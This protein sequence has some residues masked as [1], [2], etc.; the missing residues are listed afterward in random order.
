MLRFA[1][2][3]LV[4]C[5]VPLNAQ[6]ERKHPDERNLTDAPGTIRL[7]RTD[8]VA[9]DPQLRAA[10]QRL[11]GLTHSAVEGPEYARIADVAEGDGRAAVLDQGAFELVLL[12][13]TLNEIGRVGQQGSGPLD[14]RTPVGV[15]VEGSSVVRVYDAVLGFKRVATDT[16]G[17]SRL[18]SVVQPK[19]LAMS[20]CVA[21][22]EIVA[23]AP[24]SLA[25]PSAAV[26]ESEAL[27]AVF[28]ATD[29]TIIRNFGESYRASNALTRRIMSE[30]TVGCTASGFT[31][32]GYISLP[33]LRVYSPNGE[34]RW[35]Y[36]LA[37]Y[38]QAFQ[39]ER[40]NERGQLSIG[41]D[42]ST[43]RFSQTRRVVALGSDLLVFQVGNL[44]V[45][46]GRGLVELSLDT[47][48]V[49]VRTGEAVFVGSHLPYL[50][51]SA[52]QPTI[53]FLDEPEPH[54]VRLR[55]P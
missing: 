39:L 26:G 32:I 22:R 27:V 34:L 16:G 55:A 36:R 2:V 33:Y 10:A 18:L 28:S 6:S 1:F 12:D 52:T 11:R 45:R 40:S 21:G 8:T 25:N 15:S 23:L 46:R 30:A 42:Q 48:L 41:I 43:R 50:A 47:Y 20:A 49:S 44:E 9:R 31:G 17:R 14:F 29:G 54:L 19:V 53:G 38:V 5:A 7:A 37:D 51:S 13:S 35:T 24:S 3:A 4:V